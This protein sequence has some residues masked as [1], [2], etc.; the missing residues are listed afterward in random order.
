MEVAAN[1]QR[2]RTYLQE[3]RT[4]MNRVVWPSRQYVIAATLIVL[5]IVAVFIVFLM[6]VD[7]ISVN[8]LDLLVK[9]F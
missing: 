5:F 1:L 4:E 9:A 2:A 8:L 7:A 6:G 3:S